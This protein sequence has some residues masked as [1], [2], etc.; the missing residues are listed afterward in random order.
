MATGDKRVKILDKKVLG[1]VEI[2]TRFLDLLLKASRDALMPG[3]PRRGLFTSCALSAGGNDKITLGRLYG[4]DG[5]GRIADVQA[6]HALIT[7]IQF[8]NSIGVPYDVGCTIAEGPTGVE[9]N[10]RTGL[11]Q[12][13]DLTETIGYLGTPDSVVD[14]GDGTLTI[15]VDSVTEA[16]VD[17]TGRSVRVWKIAPA[18]SVIASAIDELTVAYVAG[19]NEITT[20]DLLGQTVASVIAADYAVMLMGPRIMRNTP[21]INVTDVIYIGQVQ[22]AGLGGPPAVFS[23]LDA[24]VYPTGESLVADVLE[25]C[26]HGKWRICVRAD[27]TD[28]KTPMISVK[29]SAGVRQMWI[30]E[31]GRIHHKD[32]AGGSSGIPIGAAAPAAAL[33]TTAQTLIGAINE[34]VSIFDAVLT[35]M[36]VSGCEPTAPGL[37]ALHVDDGVAISSGKR[38]PTD[39]ITVAVPDNTQGYVSWNG[40]TFA[41]ATIAP[42]EDITPVAWVK[43]AGGVITTVVDMRMLGPLDNRVD[44][45]VG[46][47]VDA[48][49]R[50]LKAA[51]DFVNAYSR[52]GAGDMRRNWRIRIC[53]SITETAV[54]VFNAGGVLI[55]GLPGSTGQTVA[56]KWSGEQALFD[57]NGQADITF[58]DLNLVYDDAGAAADATLSR[59]AFVNLAAGASGIRFENV[60]VRSVQA[61]RLHGYLYCTAEP[62]SDVWIDRC[63][64]RDASDVGMRFAAVTDLHVS[65]SK[66]TGA[67]SPQTG[68]VG[69]GRGGIILS[70]GPHS[71]VWLSK[72]YV[73]GWAD[74][75]I[76]LSATT[77]AHAYAVEIASIAVAGTTV[78][79]AGLLV[80]ASSDHVTVN[81]VSTE[82]VGIGG[83]ATTA[84]GIHVRGEHVRV[85]GCH[86][87]VDATP[88]TRQGIY[89]DSN[90]VL[91]IVDC[92]Q[93]NGHGLVI[94]PAGGPHSIG[95]SNRDD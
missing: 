12:Y 48:P 31:A 67:G 73:A 55:E 63:I 87:R 35:N 7:A 41:F 91:C 18:T 36:I 11:P 14:N 37:L 90:A 50:T 16:G 2:G 38:V 82:D 45:H 94:D 60:H 3:F 29:S 68:G 10:A 88:G 85:I 13:T 1:F 57:L 62:I 75:G 23:I 64:W 4:T 76:L 56:V 40:T 61:S 34:P 5:S 47:T 70:G 22:G 17:N 39:A 52:P 49:F 46:D 80:S 86:T 30:D 54:I 33:A 21:L 20:A 25:Q 65:K 59:F 71:R 27:A 78:I 44:L 83:V 66:I 84:R 8:E 79:A 81:D 74:Y 19:Q 32:E 77:R 58:R 9:T 15:R 93:T 26:A 24:Y 43:S 92:N 6:G 89:L 42:I 51:V 69:G 72:L 53:G 28:S 95:P